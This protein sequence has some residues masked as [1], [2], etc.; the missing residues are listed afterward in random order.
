M[1]VIK[2]VLTA[3]FI[4]MTSFVLAQSEYDHLRGIHNLVEEQIGRHDDRWTI[5]EETD[6]FTGNTN[7][8]VVGYGKQGALF[9]V[10]SCDAISVVFRSPSRFFSNSAIDS[11]WD[12]GDIVE[13]QFDN[14][15]SILVS[16]NPSLLR[17]LTKYDT[18]RLRVSAGPSS[19]VFDEFNLKNARIS[20]SED[21]QDLP[22]VRDLFRTI[23]CALK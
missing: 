18:L 2:F 3:I 23:G 21:E 16:N 8:Y 17:K 13:Y 6:F 10:A 12:N 11:I 22:H 14:R 4:S 1:K 19:F 20:V 7:R 9:I 15:N 5:H